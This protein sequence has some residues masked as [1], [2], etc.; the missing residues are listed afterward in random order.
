VLLLPVGMG[1][2]ENHHVNQPIWSGR[3][4]LTDLR[5]DD[6]V[7]FAELDWN[8]LDYHR[9]GPCPLQ[10]ARLLRLLTRCLTMLESSSRSS[11]C[12]LSAS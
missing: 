4:S 1:V 6:V 2:E 3:G 8:P 12:L 11:E 10:Y 5:A 7:P 9:E